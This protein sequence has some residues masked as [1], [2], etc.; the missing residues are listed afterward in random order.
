MTRFYDASTKTYNSDPYTDISASWARAYIDRAAELGVIHGY[1][2][3]TFRPAKNI[4]R[5]E[6]VTMV[7]NVLG[8]APSKEGFLA[9]MKTFTDNADSSAWYY[10]AIQEAT[11]SHDFTKAEGAAYETWTKINA[12]KDW[13]ALEAEWAKG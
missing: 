7:N 6:T 5:A 13:A 10:A 1:E 4:T 11:N 8:R 9:G 12:A 3:G 2:D